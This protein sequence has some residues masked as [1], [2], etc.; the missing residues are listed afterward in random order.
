[1]VLVN[2]QERGTG[3]DRKNL[4]RKRAEGTAVLVPRLFF[5]KCG[6]AKIFSLPCHVLFLSPDPGPGWEGTFELERGFGFVET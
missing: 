5:A 2:L 1:M 6:A 4:P 3:A